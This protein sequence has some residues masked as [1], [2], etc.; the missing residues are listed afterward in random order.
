MV[1]DQFSRRD[2]ANQHI[3]RRQL[4]IP[5]VRATNQLDRKT[6]GN[7]RAGTVCMSSISESI[8]FHRLNG[9]HVGNNLAK[10]SGYSYAA[11]RTTCLAT[12]ALKS[13]SFVK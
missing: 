5:R 11:D 9:R 2:V 8:C 4:R 1:R 10:W 7:P 3:S 13:E 12:F 6:G